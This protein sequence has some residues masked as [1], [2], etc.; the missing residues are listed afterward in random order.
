MKK[1]LTPYSELDIVITGHVNRIKEAFGLDFIG[2]YLQGSLA[3]GDFDMSDVDFVVV[4]KEDLSKNRVNLVQI[5]HKNTCDQNNRWV[6]RLE[7]SFFPLN[8]LKTP[9]S[10]YRSGMPDTSEERKLWCRGQH[11]EWLILMLT[12][13]ILEMVRAVLD[14]KWPGE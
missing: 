13:T 9:S 11:R 10:P 4:T 12:I 5:V 1:W 14:A 7:Y 6:R 3:I 2:A 8:T